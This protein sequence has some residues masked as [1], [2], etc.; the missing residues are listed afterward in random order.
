ML[1]ARLSA[2]IADCLSTMHL[3]ATT[4]NHPHLCI[5]RRQE[6]TLVCFA[7]FDNRNIL[8]FYNRLAELDHEFSYAARREMIKGN[9]KHRSSLPTEIVLQLNKILVGVKKKKVLQLDIEMYAGVLQVL[10][11]QAH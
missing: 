7:F 2:F 3:Q 5:G 11:S 10:F 8:H 1:Q 6:I 9:T 4:K